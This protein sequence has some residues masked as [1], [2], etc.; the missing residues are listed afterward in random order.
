M[1]F[2]PIDGSDNR[3]LGAKHG[4]NLHRNGDQGGNK[5]GGH[6]TLEHD[7]F[8]FQRRRPKKIRT[9]DKLFKGIMHITPL[10]TS[11]GPG[12][13]GFMDKITNT[14]PSRGIVLF[15]A[16]LLLAMAAAGPAGAEPDKKT[17]TYQALIRNFDI[18]AFGNEYTGRRYDNVRKWRQPIRVGIEGKYPKYFETYVLQHIRDLR[19]L[20]RP[21]HP[22]LLFPRHAQGRAPGP[23]FRPY[24]D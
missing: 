2:L 24:Q 6:E 22:A 12:I 23:G 8:P 7:G 4:P 9:G 19:K 3:I 18:I 1:D 10:R 17:A 13:V 20:H 11:P 15:T 14:A 16:L 5:H 21:F